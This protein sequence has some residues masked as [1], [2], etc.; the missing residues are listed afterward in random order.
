MN[1][2]FLQLPSHILPSHEHN[3]VQNTCSLY[4]YIDTILSLHDLLLDVKYANIGS[5]FDSDSA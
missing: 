3:C 1:I 4:F 5:L 2:S